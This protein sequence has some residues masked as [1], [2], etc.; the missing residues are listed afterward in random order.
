MDWWLGALIFALAAVG[1][2]EI[3][4]ALE[5]IGDPLAGMLASFHQLSRLL[6]W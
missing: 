2:A 1:A 6:P 3:L 5:L 4:H